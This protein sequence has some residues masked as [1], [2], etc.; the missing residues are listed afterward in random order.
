MRA[1]SLFEF[2]DWAFMRGS[3]GRWSVGQGAERLDLASG[4]R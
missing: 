3:R 2:F 1:F 4:L